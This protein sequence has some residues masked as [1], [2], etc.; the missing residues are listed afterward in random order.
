MANLV[1]RETMA[2]Y[3]GTAEFLEKR[4]QPCRHLTTLCPNECG[5]ATDV[6]VFKII[7]LD[8]KANELSSHTK[9]ITLVGAGETVLIGAKDLGVFRAVADELA[10]HTIVHLQWNHDYVTT[11]EP[12]GGSASGPERPVTGLFPK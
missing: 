12:S 1:E 9:W 4:H 8:A 5:H 2:S 11:T 7:T 3:V 6:Y 10:P